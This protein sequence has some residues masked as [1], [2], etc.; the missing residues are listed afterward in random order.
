M[1]ISIAVLSTLAVCSSAL[2]IA[3]P[4]PDLALRG[5]LNRRHKYEDD[6]T[7]IE[8]VDKLKARQSTAPGRLESRDLKARQSTAPGRLESRDNKVRQPTALGRLET[9]M[10]KA[11]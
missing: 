1:R 8:K 10:L 6:S 7:I 11:R 5:D 4:R 3:V 2:A 9:R